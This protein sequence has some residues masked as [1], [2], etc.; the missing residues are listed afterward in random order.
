MAV[1][2]ATI[3]IV[4]ALLGGLVTGCA[5]LSPAP[6]DAA[7]SAGE[8]DNRTLDDPR[9]Q[10][11]VRASQ[12]GESAPHE[13]ISWDLTGLTLAAIY[14]HPDLDV[15]RARLALSRAR[16]VTAEQRPNPILNFAAVLQTAAVAGA[17]PPGAIP[18]TIGP[19]IDF[20]VETAGKREYRLGE[21]RLLSEAATWDLA[22]AGWLVRGGVRSAFLKLWAAR[23]RI[24][25]IRG[26]RDL[27]E[28]LVRLLE[29]RL[30][31]GE[32]SALD[33]SRERIAGTQIAVEL[34]GF[35][36]AAAASEAQLASAIGVPLRALSGVR[37]GFEAFASV[38]KLPEGIAGGE[39]RRRALTGRTDIEA[40]L[41]KYEAAQSALELAVAGQYPD[42][43]LGPGYNYDA[44]INKFSLKSDARIAGLQPEPGPDRRS[45]R[46]A[47]TGR[48]GVHRA[49]GPDHRGDR[50]RARRLPGG[51]AGARN[52]RSITGRRATPRGPGRRVVPR[53]PGRSANLLVGAA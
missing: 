14:Y 24:A 33:V 36:R 42:V 52:R 6:L 17:I 35:E 40:A 7:A 51:N 19:V 38:G 46:Q 47:P 12:A 43:R 4:P 25:L 15:A 44:G 5:E 29:R 49:P 34:R 31:V 21:A 20:I 48:G 39:L 2:V 8:F 11:F 30:S 22:T 27:Q 16:V 32:T 10:T 41:A 23:Q 50:R 45:R 37:L 3:L 13:A 28:E 9:L 18:L 1:R 26:R 53:R